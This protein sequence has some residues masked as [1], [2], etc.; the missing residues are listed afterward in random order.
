MREEWSVLSENQRMLE[1]LS[2][3]LN[4]RPDF[5]DGEMVRELCESCRVPAEEAYAVLLA[6]V[7][8]LDVASD[9]LDRR[10][11]AEYLRPSVRRL[12]PSL[13]YE[14]PYCKNV[15][16][17]QARVGNWELTY[18][19]YK[20][21][22]AFASDDFIWEK[23]GRV[24]APIGFFETSVPYPAVKENGRIWMTVSPIEIHTMRPHVAA[25]RGRV[26][27]YGLG[28]GYFAY[29]ALRKSEVSSVTV[30]EHD[31]RAIA[32]F[33]EYILPCFPRSERLCIIENDA[34]SYARN[35]MPQ[36]GYDFV[37]ADTWHDPSD[38]VAMYRRFKET[39]ALYPR[40]EFRYWIEDTLRYYL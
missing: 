7:C 6:G 39:E 16:F 29:M 31:P 27:A 8:G 14:D 34:F 22:E 33:R 32:L 3:Y 2:L 4:L 5:I 38:G 11:L 13:C 12:D 9:P 35:Q 40:A 17:P 24:L 36:G 10:R 21:Y 1:A 28:L 30:V 15:R 18:E 26:L 19:S 23:D 25:A 20:P 37:F